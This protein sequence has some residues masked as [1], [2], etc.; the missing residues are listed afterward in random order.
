MRRPSVH[1]FTGLFVALKNLTI[2]I[3]PITIIGAL[4][5]LARGFILLERPQ[6]WTKWSFRK[7]LFVVV[8]VGGFFMSAFM[9]FLV[10]DYLFFSVLTYLRLEYTV[11][12]PSIRW[13]DDQ[14]VGLTS[15]LLLTRIPV[16]ALFANS[17]ALSRAAWER[18][19]PD[20]VISF[21]SAIALTL[22]LASFNCVSSSSFART[23]LSKSSSLILDVLGLADLRV[24]G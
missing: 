17:V 21:L 22:R 4:A 9:C 1:S 3:K 7:H 8:L 20:S 19:V 13:K 15:I 5:T 18:T 10:H 16:F 2:R 24:L 14:P 23:V 6:D 11:S 12:Q